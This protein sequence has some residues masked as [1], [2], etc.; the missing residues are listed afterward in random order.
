MSFGHFILM[1]NWPCPNSSANTSYKAKA[2]ILLKKN[3]LFTFKKPGF[4]IIDSVTFFSGSEFLE[5][6]NA[7]TVIEVDKK[8][9]Q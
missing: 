6:E 3:D 4:K 7:V 8:K 5:V 2:V 9:V 1:S